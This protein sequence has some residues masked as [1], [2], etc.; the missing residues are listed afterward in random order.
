MAGF[1]DSVAGHR[2]T[3]ATLPEFNR[4][5]AKFNQ[6]APKIVEDMTKEL[7]RFNDNMEK[8]LELQEKKENK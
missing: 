1:F 2:F 4:Q 5:L 7:K 6:V 8:Y 3:Q